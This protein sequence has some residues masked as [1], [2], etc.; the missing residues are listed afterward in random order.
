VSAI[1]DQQLLDAT[2]AAIHALT[3]GGHTQYSINGRSVTKHDLD[4]LWRQ[5]EKLERLV[6]RHKSGMFGLMSFGRPR[7]R[8]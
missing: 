2:V 4:A 3:V 6:A 5:R 1:T 7:P 8:K